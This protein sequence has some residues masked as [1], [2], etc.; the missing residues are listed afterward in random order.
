LSLFYDYIWLR[1]KRWDLT[2]PIHLG[3]GNISI[4]YLDTTGQRSA[5]F[6]SQSVGML[7]FGGAAQFKVFRWFALGAGV[8][9]R[10]MLTR[11]I[12][13]G[14]SLTAPYYQFQLKLLVGELYRMT[15]RRRELEA[16]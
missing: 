2:T 1:T 7:G 15:F 9:Y 6:L 13:I 11:D 12:N 4:S 14:R 10:K 5:P 16:W 3:S 8:G